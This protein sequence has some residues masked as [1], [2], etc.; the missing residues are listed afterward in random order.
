MSNFDVLTFK[1]VI[2]KVVDSLGVKS[3][4]KE[5]TTQECYLVLLEKQSVLEKEQDPT[6]LAFRIC[7]NR[8][9][10]LWDREKT[11]PVWATEVPEEK[12]VKVESLS[13]PVIAGRAAKIPALESDGLADIRLTL[14][15]DEYKVIH[16]LYVEGKSQ[17]RTA[18]DLGV[19][20]TRIRTL[21]RRGIKKLREYLGEE[22]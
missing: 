21:A 8:I 9:I 4:Q 3:Q 22:S 11:P 10:D 19:C 6:G 20:R 18:A 13:N 15:P 14:P 2:K 7:Q 1:P 12:K 17:E 5:D 16:S